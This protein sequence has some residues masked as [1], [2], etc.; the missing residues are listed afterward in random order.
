[1]KDGLIGQ[2]TIGTKEQS[3]CI[4]SNSTITILRCTNIL[5]HRITCL[6]EQAEYHNL[7]LGIVINQ[8]VAILKD[9]TIPVIIINTKWYNVWVRQPLLAAELFAV[10]CNETEYRATMDWEGDNISIGFQP[11]PPQLIDTNS[12][13]VEARPI[14]PTSPKIEK[15]VF[16]PKPDT[17][18]TDFD[19][20]NE[21]DWMPFQ[22]NIRKEANLTKDQQS[23]FINLEYDNKEVFSL[24]DEDLGY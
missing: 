4:P 19:F 7:L 8:C 2:V 20:K 5:L 10:E 24:H 18:S 6:V 16:C 23:C 11:V 9:R 1:M 21:I 3:I 15:P 12:C 17:N 14:Q 13:E 22:L